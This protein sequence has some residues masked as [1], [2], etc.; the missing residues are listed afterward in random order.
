VCAGGNSRL[1]RDDAELTKHFARR[2]P[3]TQ[4][5]LSRAE[6]RELQRILLTRGHDVGAPS[7]VLTPGAITA[8]KIEQERLGHDATGRPGQRLLKALRV[9]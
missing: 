5:G 6:R 3:R 2:G 9:P 7:G 1:R 8:V 4:L